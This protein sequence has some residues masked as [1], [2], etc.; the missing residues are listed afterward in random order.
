V[1]AIAVARKAL[2]RVLPRL[3]L[4]MNRLLILPLATALLATATPVCPAALLVVAPLG[5]ICL[6]ATAE[7]TPTVGLEKKAV[8]LNL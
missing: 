7:M 3:L 4:A 6:L 8:C 2:C 5:T 1:E